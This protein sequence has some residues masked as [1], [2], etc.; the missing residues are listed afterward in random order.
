VVDNLTQLDQGGSNCQFTRV[1][2]G[3]TVGWVMLPVVPELEI[4]LAAGLFLGNFT[5]RVLLKAACKSVNLPACAAWM[6][7]QYQ[8]NQ[9]A[10]DRSIWIK[11]YVG[12]ASA[13]APIVI[14]PNGADVI[15]GLASFKM[16]T[17]YSL[18][19]LYPLTDLSGWYV[20]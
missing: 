6:L 16:I 15:D 10:F 20:G 2:L 13:G 8:A 5:S 17:P 4:T 3:P 9:A 14:T 19:R 1:Y 12:D 11:D 7:A 18:I